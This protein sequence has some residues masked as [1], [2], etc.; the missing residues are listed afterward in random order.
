MKRIIMNNTTRN[1]SKKLGAFLLASLL[2]LMTFSGQILAEEVILEENIEY[3]IEDTILIEEEQEE[4]N[5][6]LDDEILI[7]GD[8]ETKKYIENQ[9]GIAITPFKAFPEDIYLRWTGTLANTGASGGNINSYIVSMPEVGDVRAFCIDADLPGYYGSVPISFANGSAISE[10]YKDGLT[11]ILWISKEI[12]LDDAST[13]AAIHFLEHRLGLTTKWN[14]SWSYNNIDLA[15]A[16][17]I[18]ADATLGL[19]SYSRYPYFHIE[20]SG[21]EK[22]DANNQLKIQILTTDCDSW[23]LTL[24]AGVSASQTTG[25]TGAL[26]TLTLTDPIAFFASN[27]EISG[28]GT[29]DFCPS[30]AIMFITRDGYQDFVLL[31]MSAPSESDPHSRTLPQASYSATFHK[32]T[33]RLSI[34]TNEKDAAFDVFLSSFGS[35]ELASNGQ[36]GKFITNNNGLSTIRDLMPGKYTVRQTFAPEG[37]IASPDFEVV[38]PHNGN[39]EIVNETAYGEVA[40]HKLMNMGTY[41]VTE[42]GAKF[43]VYSKSAGTYETAKAEEKDFLT[44]DVNGDAKT[45]LLPYGTYVF[46]QVDGA[47]GTIFTDDF[48]LLIGA[49]HQE[50]IQKEI[51]N[52][53]CWGKIEIHK[54]TVDP[55]GDVQEFIPEE[56]A[57]FRI[58]KKNSGSFSSASTED[59]DE[60][61]TDVNG[62][63][64]SKNLPYGIYVVEQ[65]QTLETSGTILIEPF[66]IFIGIDDSGKDVNGFVY[67]KSLFN[68]PY[69]QHLRVIKTNEETGEIIPLSGAV[70]Q[71]LD[72]D[73]NLIYGSDGESEFS[74]N[75][76]GEANINTIAFV[77]GKYYLKEIKAPLGFVLTNSLLEIEI[78]QEDKGKSYIVSEKGQD[79]REIYFTNC[80]QKAEIILEKKGEVVAEV[81]YIPI[82]E[83]DMEVLKRG[84]FSYKEMPLADVSFEVFVGEKDILNFSGQGVRKIDLDG[85][86]INETELN[87]GTSLGVIKTNQEGLAVM[88]DLPLDANTGMA[89]YVVKELSS[90]KGYVVSNEKITFDFS[91]GNQNEDKVSVS[92]TIVNELQKNIVTL[93]KEKETAVWDEEK[94]AF[95][96]D[97]IPAEDIVFGLYTKKDIISDITGEILVEA[98]ELVDVLVTNAEGEAFSTANLPFGE[99]YAKEIKVT[100]DV[101][102][103][104][105]TEYPVL[106]RAVFFPSEDGQ[107][108]PLQN[109]DAILNGMIAGTLSIY[110]E[111]ED[112]R[113]PMSDVVFSLFDEKGNL[114][115]TL[116]T[117]EKGCAATQ[118]LPKGVYTLLEVKTSSGYILSDKI[119]IDIGIQP[120]DGSRY[121]EHF[122]KIGNKPAPVEPM[123]EVVKTGEGASASFS[124]GLIIFSMAMAAFFIYKRKE[125]RA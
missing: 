98:N 91:Y 18:S 121:S 59:K 42:E 68:A 23:S 29:L 14:P 103:D 48:E 40:L 4:V 43:E 56:G 54:S 89:Q 77:P 124:A 58:Y 123:K 49:K 6:D 97:A 34:K 105:M 86:G 116:I 46:H 94:K 21:T 76:R 8:E 37:T 63:G 74:T 57:K 24:P 120:E 61:V 2:F 92:K 118:I 88:G 107:F 26:V 119:T 20:I 60:F 78:S 44:T 35:Y 62:V 28:L 111:A 117:D 113:L 12:G 50:V 75:E 15:V 79:I 30:E 45:K 7:V 66:E 102:F 71:A 84:L 65:I 109:G 104:E 1:A 87:A 81:Q 114:V 9:E 90:Q 53:I 31:D 33:N 32:S 95:S 96:W 122:L 47:P 64:I 69:Y 82:S 83:K 70:F 101:F 51:I 3:E 110:K 27:R 5:A 39:I 41:T 125:K 25:T 38:L 11:Y 115:E 73:K 93:K 17:Q 19:L 99:Y 72:K 55:N 52:E 10:A 112:S 80:E 22:W 13:S 85:D 16:R 108:F 67:K 100:P 106:V 36:R